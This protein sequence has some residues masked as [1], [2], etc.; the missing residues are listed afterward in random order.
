MKSRF[1]I[2]WGMIVLTVTMATSVA[3]AETP[4]TKAQELWRIKME[5]DITAREERLAL[6]KQIIAYKQADNG[7][8]ERAI[9]LRKQLLQS[10][11]SQR[12]ALRAEFDRTMAEWG[13]QREGREAVQ[14]QYVA[15]C[16]ERPLRMLQL[17]T[18]ELA[19][20]YACMLDEPL[21]AQLAH[22]APNNAQFATLAASRA[23]LVR[24]M[25]TEWTT[26]KTAL[27]TELAAETQ[28]RDALLELHVKETELD[29]ALDQRIDAIHA[30]IDTAV[31]AFEGYGKR[32]GELSKQMLALVKAPQK[33]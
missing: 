30:R 24:T 6:R 5:Y 7:F 32:L 22:H 16:Y 29:A 26:L 14:A 10:V 21:N 9:A 25:Q 23:A 13:K 33:N 12:E 2:D 27:D 8:D 20:R 31:T 1:W 19:A 3:R 11:P 15:L 4:C 17:R 18:Q 28:T